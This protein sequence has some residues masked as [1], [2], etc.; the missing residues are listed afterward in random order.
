MAEIYLSMAL[1][2]VLAYLLGSIPTAVWLGRWI[3]GLDVRE[4]GSGNAGAT[5][6]MRVLGPRVGLLVLIIDAMKGIGPSAWP[7]W[8]KPAP[9]RQNGLWFTKC[10]WGHWRFLAMYFLCSLP[11]KGARVSPRSLASYLFFSRRLF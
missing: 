10:S 8:P 1:M 5:N 3:K 9:C 11:L 4:H 6:A 7:T 2:V